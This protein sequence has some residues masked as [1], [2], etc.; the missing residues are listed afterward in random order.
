MRGKDSIDLLFTNRIL[1]DKDRFC[2][3][4]SIVVRKKLILM[5]IYA[6]FAYENSY[7]SFIVF[8][9]I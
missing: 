8:L 5:F 2:D 1:T 7:V 3:L 9:M 6:P 4:N